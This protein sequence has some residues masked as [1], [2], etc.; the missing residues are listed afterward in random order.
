MEELREQ[1]NKLLQDNLEQKQTIRHLNSSLDLMKITIVDNEVSRATSTKTN[2]NEKNTEESEDEDDE[3]ENGSDGN[4]EEDSAV[5]PEGDEYDLKTQYDA[6][7]IEESDQVEEEEVAENMDLGKDKKS[8]DPDYQEKGDG[9]DR[10]NH[11]ESKDRRKKYGRPIC[12]FYLRGNCDSNDQDCWFRHEKISRD[13]EANTGYDYDKKLERKKT[14]VCRHFLRDAC[15]YSAEDCWFLHK[16]PTGQYPEKGS[17]RENWKENLS[18]NYSEKDSR[19]QENE[20]WK[21]EKDYHLE[22]KNSSRSRSRYEKNQEEP[23]EKRRKYRG[24]EK[25]GKE[26]KHKQAPSSE[27]ALQE[28][29]KEMKEKMMSF[30]SEGM[31]KIRRQKLTQ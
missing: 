12:R 2:S 27:M 22:R 3:D 11:D 8:S 14:R 18:E 24:D 6:T 9:M 15:H 19:S 4:G 17:R 26:Y 1:K 28:F 29:E 25:D 16:K 5:D 7:I 20:R 30:L 23:E 10:P 21:P 13:K 31:K